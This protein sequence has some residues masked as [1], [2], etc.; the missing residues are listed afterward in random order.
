MYGATLLDIL[1]NIYGINY[2]PKS[3]NNFEKLY[4]E[5]GRIA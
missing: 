2:V 3:D 1:E 4:Y 5:G